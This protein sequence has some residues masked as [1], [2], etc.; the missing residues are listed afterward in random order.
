MSRMA[1][2]VLMI[3]AIA[4]LLIQRSTTT[5]Q[6]MP[7]TFILLLLGVACGYCGKLCVDTL[8]GSGSLWLLYWE[9]LCMLHFLSIVCTP[10]LFQILHGPVT[11]SQATKQ[12]TIIPY[13]IRR[14]WFYATLLV[15]LPL[16][17][18]LTPFTSLD[19]WKDHFLFKVS[20][21]NRFEWKGHRLVMENRFLHTS[22]CLWAAFLVMS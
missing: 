9:I 11:A 18:G 20:A 7:V 21:F 17:C 22:L 6:T 15:F 5:S 12:N 4:Y 3:F 2:G 13:W 19:Q 8:G 14:F 10:I 1:F 16:F